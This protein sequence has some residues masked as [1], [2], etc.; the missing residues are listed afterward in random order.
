MRAPQRDHMPHG[1]RRKSG[2]MDEFSGLA[3]AINV[4]RISSCSPPV[5]GKGNQGFRADSDLHDAPAATYSVRQVITRPRKRCAKK[6]GPRGSGCLKGPDIRRVLDALHAMRAAGMAPALFVT[7][8]APL[9]VTDAEGKRVMSRRRD[10]MRNDIIGHGIEP[11]LWIAIA[12]KGHGAL[13]A[14]E[15]WGLPRKMS[16]GIAELWAKRWG[17][18]VFA[19]PFRAD[20]AAYMTK[21]RA[22]RGPDIEAAHPRPRQPAERIEGPRIAVSKPLRLL[23][24]EAVAVSR[25]KAPTPQPEQPAPQPPVVIDANAPRQL[26]LFI[27]LEPTPTRAEQLRRLR[28]EAGMTQAGFAEL[29]GLRQPHVA[30]VERGHD[31]VAYARL[32]AARWQIERTTA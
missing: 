9:G 24:G 16:A 25:T 12:E 20:H 18:D 3:A 14:H 13:H 19:V 28:T 29:I 5:E 8:R 26:P 7:Q 23:L 15:A 2:V 1:A 6:R 4:P 21:Q 10:R 17:A 31:P 11:L 27:H 32:R 30:N 22:F